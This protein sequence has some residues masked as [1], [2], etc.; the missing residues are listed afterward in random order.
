MGTKGM[1]APNKV[2]IVT[3][4]G[5]GVGKATSL[6]MARLG[7]H[8]IV[9]YSRS[10]DEADTTVREITALGVRAF[11]VQ[12]DV[13]NDSE[14][15]AMVAFAVRE[16]G[17]VDVLVNCAGTTDFIPFNDLDAVSDEAWERL[18]KVNVVGTFHCVR[19]V[20]EPMLAVGGG[21]I[22]NVSS[23]AA[24]LGQGSSIPYCCTKA[25]LD[26]LTV[27]LARTLAPQ[28]RVNGIAPGFIEGR[29][30]QGGLGSKYDS[31]KQAYEKTLPLGRVCQPEDIADGIVS[32]ITGSKLVTGQTLT[33]DA[34]MM[35]SGFQVK[36]G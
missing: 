12:A 1:S 11:A 15:R 29:W 24:Q 31:I 36:F 18:Y 9:N 13:A 33:V 5:T 25:A 23:V 27:S 26:N 22:I 6:A 20:R 3:G 14:C 34:G 32:L 8:V 7:Y 35:I 16:L 2:V 19:A 30:T 4:G 21:I 17:R 28:I 10:K